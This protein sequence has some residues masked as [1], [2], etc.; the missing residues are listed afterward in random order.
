MNE[1]DLK[2]G[3]TLKE[4]LQN[5]PVI[6]QSIF[7][8][9][10]LFLEIQQ[11]K[12]DIDKAT[13]FFFRHDENNEIQILISKYDS[14]YASIKKLMQKIDSDFVQLNS[15][16]KDPLPLIKT[17]LDSL[18][19]VPIINGEF[20]KLQEITEKERKKGETVSELLKTLNELK[21]EC[22]QQV[23]IAKRSVISQ[24]EIDY[25][26]SLSKY[27]N[28]LKE[29]RA[30][31]KKAE[32]EYNE[33]QK[34]K[35]IKLNELKL[36]EDDINAKS[37]ARQ[38][39]INS[40]L[41]ELKETELTL[42]ETEKLHEDIEKNGI[43][44]NL[45]REIENSELKLQEINESINN[46]KLELSSVNSSKENEMK[47]LDQKII[48]LQNSIHSIEE[49]LEILPSPSEWK[50]MQME[51]EKY[52]KIMELNEKKL[53]LTKELNQVTEDI[54]EQKKELVSKNNELN[55]L[56]EKVEQEKIKLK[57]IIDTKS[58]E[59]KK[60]ESNKDNE[61]LSVLR[62]Q[63][64]SLTLSKTNN[65]RQL[66]V[67]QQNN[68]ILRS[69]KESLEEQIIQ[70]KKQTKYV[71]LESH[72]I[73][74]PENLQISQ[75]SYK[76]SLSSPKNQSFIAKI[77]QFFYDFCRAKPYYVLI[78]FLYILLLHILINIKLFFQITLK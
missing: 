47:E 53:E 19:K 30:S 9:D 51:Y 29:A 32:V 13:T 34:S 8:N 64:E 5:W 33:L 1:F 40:L 2:A 63:I 57:S 61:L 39:Q 11:E 36:Q 73:I 54:Q 38:E 58:L 76:D 7:S 72:N 35:N 4:A 16:I 6:N 26:M 66:M 3:E 24:S 28:Q 65:E 44:Q 77:S 49:Q 27:N 70:L 42:K 45:S 68:C 67:L 62:S 41:S 31:L 55:E 12:D 18:H 56:H 52:K 71:N 69:E 14:Y 21:K 25:E 17:A 20:Q 43:I 23:L 50:K 22:D 10:D 15:S 59:N 78:F 46:V 74:D 75:A 48:N 60:L 37:I